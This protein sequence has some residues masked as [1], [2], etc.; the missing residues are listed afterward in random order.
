MELQLT[1]DATWI[2]YLFAVTVTLQSGYYMLH[3][4]SH[5]TF[6]PSNLHILVS[7]AYL[8]IF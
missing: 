1:V 6:A 4:A 3:S 2:P 8:L 5:K 7:R